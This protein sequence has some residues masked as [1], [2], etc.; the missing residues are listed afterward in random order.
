MKNFYIAAMLTMALAS[1]CSKKPPL[2]ELTS[3]DSL[4]IVQENLRHR[5]TMDEYFRS[6]PSSPFSRDTSVTYQGIRW[7]P[8]DPRLRGI[9]VLHH[10]THP[11]TVRV[12]GTKGEQRKQLKYGYF[13]FTI[14]DPE[15]EPRTV[16]M[17]VYKFTPHDPDRYTRFRDNLS[18]WFTDETTGKETYDVGRYLNV[19]NEVP[20]P[21]YKY[22]IDFNKA[23]NP[24][25]AYSSIFSCAIPRE[26]DHI[27]IP[28]RAGEKKY[29]E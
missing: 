6:N 19:G 4:A 29:H 13:L 25:C 7:F 20:K 28:I 26:E 22:L 21:S 3:S 16:K 9:S 14:P 17:N 8:I 5:E 12:M 15:G 1:G 18:V 24:Y 11:E 27:D 10:Y 23:Y 2:P